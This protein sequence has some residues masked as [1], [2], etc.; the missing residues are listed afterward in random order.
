ME[1]GRKK[2]GVERRRRAAE[3]KTTGGAEAKGDEGDAENAIRGKEK[4][5]LQ[6]TALLTLAASLLIQRHQP[7]PHASAATAAEGEGRAMT[8]ARMMRAKM[9]KTRMLVGQPAKNVVERV[10]S[11]L[12]HCYQFV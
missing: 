8:T 1:G 2:M 12:S 9:M 6:R 4:P 3:S 10:S 7:R 5:P 11:D